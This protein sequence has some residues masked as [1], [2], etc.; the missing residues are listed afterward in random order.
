MKADF[1]HVLPVGDVRRPLIGRVVVATLMASAI[2]FAFTATKQMGSLYVHAPWLNDPFDAA[3][4]FT[5]FFVPLVVAGF[6]VQATLCRKSDSLPIDRVV[7]IIRGSRVTVGAITFE[8]LTAWVAVALRENRADWTL[9]STGFLIALLIVATF[10]TIRA[11]FLLY[12]APSFE[13]PDRSAITRTDWLGDVVAVA[14]KETRWLGPLH[15]QGYSII[16][17]IDRVLVSR[18]RP[19]PLFAASIMSG[20][21][22]LVIFGH[23]GIIE[24]YKLPLTL[25]FMGIGFCGIFA[26]FVLA[27]SYIGF[28]RSPN[29]MHGAK[30]RLLDATV[31]GCLSLVLALAFRGSI[32][33]VIGGNNSAS[34]LVQLITL[35]AGAGFLVLLVV[36]IL[37]S[38]LRSHSKP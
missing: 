32:W 16:I 17:W 27:G 15:R 3:F 34:G 11:I 37:E 13:A 6:L 33:G 18:V 4:S 35:I 5:M 30:R 2:F 8:L 19:H 1:P 26:F 31:A 12:R 10:V 9:D 24:G 23:Q 28:V 21:L 22:A 25:L 20:L 38:V 14:K 7:T 29:P 36:F